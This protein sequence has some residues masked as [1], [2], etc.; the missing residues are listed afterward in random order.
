MGRSDPSFVHEECADNAFKSPENGVTYTEDEI[1]QFLDKKKK[2]VES[3]WSCQDCGFFFEAT[4]ADNT[5][6]SLH[7]LECTFNGKEYSTL[8]PL[9]FLSLY[10]KVYYTVFITHIFLII[11]ENV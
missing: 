7:F 8:L 1:Q 3:C 5:V 10:L 4:K 6:L 2:I 11:N 9:S